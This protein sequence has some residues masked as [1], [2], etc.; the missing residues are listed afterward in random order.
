LETILFG[1]RLV[2]G[3]RLSREQYRHSALISP[4]Y[5]PERERRI[6]GT[7]LSSQEGS[8]ES[9]MFESLASRFAFR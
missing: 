8:K 5:H 2:R 6:S 1:L 9:K 4:Q 3:G 7:F